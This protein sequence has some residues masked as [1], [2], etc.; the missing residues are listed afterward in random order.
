MS[1]RYVTYFWTLSSCICALVMQT[2]HQAC[3][4]AECVWKK[5]LSHIRWSKASICH[6]VSFFFFFSIS[7]M[8]QTWCKTGRYPNRKKEVSVVFVCVCSFF[9][10]TFAQWTMPTL[11]QELHIATIY[12]EQRN[13]HLCCYSIWHS[14]LKGICQQFMDHTKQY[15][16]IWR[17]S[18]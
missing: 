18:I 7:L 10:K 8:P 14:Y 13:K 11:K 3:I 12:W 4:V 9:S 6:H 5:C 16:H 1:L 2:P 15:V 17:Y